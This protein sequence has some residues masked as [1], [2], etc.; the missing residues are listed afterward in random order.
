L[1]CKD[2]LE[3]LG[4]KW[5]ANGVWHVSPRE[6][7]RELQTKSG[8]ARLAR[9]SRMTVHRHGLEP[10]TREALEFAMRK[11][12]EAGIPLV[13]TA[14][15]GSH[16]ELPA[17]LVQVRNYCANLAASS[18]RGPVPGVRYRAPGEPTFLETPG[19]RKALELGQFVVEPPFDSVPRSE[20]RRRLDRLLW[21]IEVAKHD[22]TIARD[23]AE[24]K[25]AARHMRRVMSGRLKKWSSA[26]VKRYATPEE[27]ERFR[28]YE[29]RRWI[30]RTKLDPLGPV[31]IGLLCGHL[32][33]S[34]SGFLKWRQHLRLSH[35]K[36]LDLLLAEKRHVAEPPGEEERP[37]KPRPKMISSVDYDPQGY[38]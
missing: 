32:G 20:Q 36:Y 2:L 3:V 9:V 30:A 23:V 5:V 27:Q 33:I 24:W 21:H 26:Q 7:I 38:D 10:N 19:S 4:L 25:L 22:P 34:R 12:A 37:A 8:I 29:R 31:H 14:A 35:R 15:V 1:S 17:R 13:E 28:D 16:A 11:R 6:I 18:C